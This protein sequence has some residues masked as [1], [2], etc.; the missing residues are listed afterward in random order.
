[1]TASR[2][3]RGDLEQLPDGRWRARYRENGR[4]GRRPQRTFAS[5]AEASE[6]L[7]VGLGEAKQIAGGDTQT[8]VRRREAQ[9]TVSDAVRDYLAAH[10][11]SDVRIEKL[12]DRLRILERTF[13]PRPIQTLEPY[14]LQT[15]R[16]TISPG[17]R[18]DV[19]KAANQLFRQATRWHWIPVNPCD[20]VPNPAPRRREV[21][22]M[23]WASIVAARAEIDLGYE[24]VPVLAAGTGLRPEEWIPLERSDLD[25][26]GRVLHVRRV[27][28]SGRL[29][30]LGPDGQKTGLQRRAVPLRQLVIDEL[31]QMPP[32]IDTP[33][34]FPGRGG[35]YVNWDWFGRAVWR[36]ALAAA[37]VQHQ[38]PYDMRHTYA[39]DSI[40]AGVDLFTLS[41][42]MGTSLEQ[43]DKTYGHLTHD[44]VDRELELLDAWDG[45]AST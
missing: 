12:R 16:K 8:I 13:G 6:W 19:F 37:G 38:R 22:P 29:T 17:Y 28:S 42:R 43:I 4:T 27:Y 20:G 3:Q 11:A 35:G 2:G 31:R 26:A 36:P 9:R 1:M 33:L 39:T 44:A 34:L 15:W 24:A 14:E 40:A 25:L 32:R 7:R 18:H 5:R 41:R 21:T 10:E 23:P 45:T 30:S